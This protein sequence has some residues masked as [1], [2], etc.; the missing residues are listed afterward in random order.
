MDSKIY[1]INF[2]CLCRMRDQYD[3]ND[4]KVKQN[5]IFIYKAT[6]KVAR[7]NL[8]YFKCLTCCRTLDGSP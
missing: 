6:P 3:S 4:L 1:A 8:K 2:T 7:Q 5:K